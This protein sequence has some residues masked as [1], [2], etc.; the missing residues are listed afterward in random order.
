MML[1]LHLGCVIKG[2][3]PHFELI[4]KA[5]HKR[6]NEFINYITKNQLEMEYLHLSK[7]KTS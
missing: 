3:T 1:S 2:K 7:Q 4:S 5:V 6:N